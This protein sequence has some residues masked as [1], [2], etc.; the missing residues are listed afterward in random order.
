MIRK[1]SKE[2]TLF[3]K[4][5]AAAKAAMHSVTDLA[6]R[7]NTPVIIYR[8]GKIERLLPNSLA[9]DNAGEES[10]N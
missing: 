7:T 3:D 9:E 4:A 8:N 10:G 5:N 6:R 2:P 1:E